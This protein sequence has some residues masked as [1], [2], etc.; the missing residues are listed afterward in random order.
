MTNAEEKYL[1]RIYT[2]PSHP[3]S[4]S[5]PSKLK[6]V[7]D[8]EGKFKISKGDI[9]AFLE[10]QDSYTVNRPVRH[11]FRRGRIVTRGIKDQYDLDLIDMARLSKYNDNVKFLL[12][13]VDT[14][15]RVA[16][17]IA[18]KQKTA[19]AVLEALKVILSDE[20]KCRV[21]RTDFGAEF[22]N[23]K[24]KAFLDSKNIKHFYAHAPLKAQIVERFNQTLKQLIYRYL[25]NRNSYRYIDNLADIVKS[26]NNRPHRS[27]GGLSPNQVSK[28]NE[29][30]LWNE[31]YVNRPYNNSRTSRR[32]TKHSISQLRP[33]AKFRL[34]QGDLVRV[35]FNRRAFERSFY[36]RFSE[37]VF[38]IKQ[39]LIRDNIPLYVLADLNGS[40]IKGFFYGPELQRVSHDANKTFK[41]EKVLKRRGKGKKRE[42]LVRWVGYGPAFD[43]WIPYSSIES[44]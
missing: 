36:Q 35:T 26:Y 31:M 10:K 42:A 4:F 14:F 40:V 24:V 33:A 39:R 12:T 27:L 25:H 19:D 23:F 5:G 41:I 29:I 38:R 37:E 3:A 32:N 21:L 8:R 44:I 6:Q 30:S 7:V 20:N 13:S 2:D 28:E 34:K 18:L 43:Q 16:M 1:T 17:V 9:K 22:K 11:K 15:S